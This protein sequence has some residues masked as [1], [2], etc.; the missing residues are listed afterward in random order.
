MGNSCQKKTPPCRRSTTLS[1]PC[2]DSSSSWSIVSAQHEEIA[3]WLR[4]IILGPE[5]SGKLCSSGAYERIDNLKPFF[6]VLGRRP[7]QHDNKTGLFNCDWVCPKRITGYGALFVVY[8][9]R[10]CVRLT[11]L[12]WSFKWFPPRLR[13]NA[14][15]RNGRC[16]QSIHIFNSLPSLPRVFTAAS[17]AWWIIILQTTGVLLPTNQSLVNSQERN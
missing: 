10:A 12:V 13:R 3:I 7:T 17:I 15:P 8:L 1:Y 4:Y 2:L 9:W 16:L 6:S 14:K 5:W 11:A